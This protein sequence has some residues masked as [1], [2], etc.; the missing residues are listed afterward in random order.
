M[1]YLIYTF[2]EGDFYMKKLLSVSLALLLSLTMFVGCNSGEKD[3]EGSENNDSEVVVMDGKID[4]LT[5]ISLVKTLGRTYMAEDN[6]LWLCYSGTGVDFDFVG[7]KCTITIAGDSNATKND[8]ANNARIAI[9]VNGERIVDDM[10]NDYF[11]TYTVF[12]SEAEQTVNVKVIKLS[13]SAMSV[14]GISKIEVEG[15]EVKPAAVSDKKIEFI[16]D[17]ITCGYGV[18]D[19]VKENHFMT[20]TEDTTKAYAYLTAKAL[21][22]DYSMVCLSGHGIISGYSN[23]GNKVENQIMPKFYDYLGFCYGS[24]DSGKQPQNME[25]NH[26]DYQPDLVVINLGTNDDSYCQNDAEKQ[27]DYKTQYIEFL[28]HIREVNPDAHILCT[29]GVMGDRLYPTIESVVADYTAQTGDT[30]VSSMKFDVQ[31]PADGYAADWHP[32]A[33]T[34]QKAADKLTAHIKELMNW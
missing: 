29:L 1:I 26:A 5:D 23:D 7:T 6:K 8:P 31:S 11:K 32:T 25:W 20:S 14:C 28:K 4:V 10:I 18:D 30:N 15:S 16:G 24:F 19:L 27:L 9:E 33:V 2:T 12:E 34:Q 13:E 3:S 21:G 22:A 17:S